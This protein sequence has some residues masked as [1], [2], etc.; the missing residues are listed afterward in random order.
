MSWRV[1][2]AVDQ[3]LHDASTL[4]L[5]GLLKI[6]LLT[7]VPSGVQHSSVARE[8]HIPGPLTIPQSGGVAAAGLRKRESAEEDVG[9][10][11]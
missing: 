7:V 3:T 4:R 5:V 8:T 9:L 6:A 11:C 1:V 10:A 2:G